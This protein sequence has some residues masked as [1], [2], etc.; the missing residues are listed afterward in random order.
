MNP[1][2]G[3]DH[4]NEI[5]TTLLAGGGVKGG[6]I[7]GKSDA[8]GA[9]SVDPGWKHR[10]QPH[11]DNIVATIYSALGVDWLKRVENTPSGRAYEYIETAPIGGNEFISNDDI[12]ELFV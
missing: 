3:R 4:Y 7:V 8:I 2:A 11:M 5:Y 9:F 1:V 12:A 6:R 10:E